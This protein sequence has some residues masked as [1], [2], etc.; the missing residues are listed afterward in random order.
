MQIR[1]YS[2]VLA[3]VLSVACGAWA[4]ETKNPVK[5]VTDKTPGQ[6]LASPEAVEKNESIES[7]DPLTDDRKTTPQGVITDQPIPIIQQIV[8]FVDATK[9]PTDWLS[10]GADLRMREVWADNHINLDDSRDGHEFHY[11]RY[12]FRLWTKIDFTESLSANIRAVWEPRNWCKPGDRLDAANGGGSW[13]EGEVVFDHMNIQ[14]KDAFNLPLTLTVGR[15]DIVV[16]DGWLVRD[17]TPLDGSR[18]IYFDAARAQVELKPIQTK[19]DIAYIYM[20]AMQEDQWLPPINDLDRAIATNDEQGVVVNVTNTTLHNQ[21]FSAF[22][23]Y[24]HN[25]A[26]NLPRSNNADIYTF[27]LRAAGKLDKEE[28]WAYNAQI[29]KQFGN[30]DGASIDAFGAR[31]NLGYHVKDAYDNKFGLTYEFLSGDDPS[32]SDNEAFDILWGRYPQ[33]SEIATYAWIP[34]SGYAQ[35]TN[36]HRVTADWSCKPTEALEFGLAYNLLWAQETPLNGTG[37][38]GSGHFRGQVGRA[39]LRYRFTDHITGHLVGEIFAPGNYYQSPHDDI[40]LFARYEI[41]ITW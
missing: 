33:F 36:L 14:Y 10:W 16:N 38:F 21:E 41:T 26:V 3:L 8:E 18:T 25:E 23:I 37:M 11:Q 34:E 19:V 2:M 28:H 29:A 7:T 5:P 31:A 24:K 30:R 13:D 40:A 15:Q 20:K 12:R 39:L 1:N 4:E 27:G 32:T 17:G 22:F 9:Q 6:K 35:A